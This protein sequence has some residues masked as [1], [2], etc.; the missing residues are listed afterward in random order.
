VE[1]TANWKASEAFALG[2]LFTCQR[3]EIFEEDLDRYI[4][5]GADTVSPTRLTVYPS[6][7]R[8]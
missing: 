5:F 6:L 4:P 7:R 2:G 3:G 1:A 8:I